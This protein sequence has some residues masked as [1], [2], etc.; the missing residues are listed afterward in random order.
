MIQIFST[1]HSNFKMLIITFSFLFSLYSSL[2]SFIF[3]STYLFI[4]FLLFAFLPSFFNQYFF[5]LQDEEHTPARLPP[6]RALWIIHRWYTSLSKISYWQKFFLP[7]CFF[8]LKVFQICRL[9]HGVAL[10]PY[11]SFLF[12]PL[13]LSSLPAL[14]SPPFSAFSTHHLLHD[15]QYPPPIHPLPSPP[16]PFLPS[17]FLFHLVLFLLNLFF[18]PSSPFLSTSFIFHLLSSLSLDVVLSDL[19]L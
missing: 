12:P 13:L 17:F 11:Y 19:I 1:F 6:N 8:L 4:L 14:I 10:H 5:L 7:Y 16:Y 3:Y 9:L 2:S 18:P 15:L